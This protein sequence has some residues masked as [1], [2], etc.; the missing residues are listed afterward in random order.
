MKRITWNKY[1]EQ[2]WMGPSTQNNHSSVQF[3]I[4]SRKQDVHSYSIMTSSALYEWL[5]INK[6]RHTAS[7]DGTLA[8]SYCCVTS[9]FCSNASKCHWQMK[10]H[11]M[12]LLFVYSGAKSHKHV[13]NTFY[14]CLPLHWYTV[15]LILYQDIDIGQ[16]SL[17]SSFSLKKICSYRYDWSL[18]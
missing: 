14:I 11:Q 1:S 9:P 4:T 10:L 8:L 12:T 6:P 17:Y 2:T 13:R 18:E 15:W 3:L 7:C 16:H 5:L